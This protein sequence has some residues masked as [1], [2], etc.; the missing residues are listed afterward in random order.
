MIRALCVTFVLGLAVAGCGSSKSPSSSATTPISVP[1][2]TTTPA[3][4]S[5]TALNAVKARFVRAKL[6]PKEVSLGVKELDA[7]EVRHVDAIQFGAPAALK[8]YVAQLKAFF[9][10]HPAGWTHIELGLRMYWTG[11]EHAL[12]AAQLANFHH[13]VAVGQGH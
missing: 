2:T 6:F 9:T 10:P 3:L 4:S 11:D 12:T 8:A 7:V 13:I 1:A 5:R